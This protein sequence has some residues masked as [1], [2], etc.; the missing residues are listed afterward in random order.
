M[1]RA[2]VKGLKSSSIELAWLT[3]SYALAFGIMQGLFGH[4]GLDI[5]M[6]NN[7]V[8]MSLPVAA[9]PLF[10]AIASVITAIRLANSRWKTPYTAAVMIGLALL[11]LFI[12]VVALSIARSIMRS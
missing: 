7:Y 12:V 8:V 9:T 6:H 4:P 3:G 5:Q 10:A 2:A 11:W 1:Q